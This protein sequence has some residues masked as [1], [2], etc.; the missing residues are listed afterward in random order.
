MKSSSPTSPSPTPTPPTTSSKSRPTVRQSF[1]GTSSSSALPRARASPSPGNSPCAPS[2][3]DASISPKP[4]PSA[5]SSIRRRLYQ[6][7]VAAQQLEG[8]LSRR[9][10]PIK[11]KLVEL[12]ATLE[13]G[14]DFAEDD[15]SVLPAMKFS[16][17][18]R[19]CAL[20]SKNWPGFCLRKNCP[21]RPD[22]RHRGTSKRRQ[23]QPVQSPG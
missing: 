1:C 15:V 3:T 9:L 4:K 8:A 11:Q 12:I 7:K 23:V 22:A 10:Q 2:L 19:P 6:A 20:H 13:A 17:G 5:T 21:R 14:V 18:S 16:S